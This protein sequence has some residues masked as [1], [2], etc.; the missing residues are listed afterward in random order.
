MPIL[1]MAAQHAGEKQP[2]D[3]GLGGD[4]VEDE[5]DRRRN[6]DAERAAGAN[7]AGGNVIR[8]T[9]LAHLRNTHFADGR[10][11]GG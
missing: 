7:R 1:P 8:I 2:P 3:G 9:A 6:Q 5:G 11:A 4:A 10:A